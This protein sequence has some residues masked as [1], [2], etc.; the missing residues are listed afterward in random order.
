MFVHQHSLTYIHAVDVKEK[1]AKMDKG[2][3]IGSWGQLQ[4]RPSIW[5]LNRYSTD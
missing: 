1:K 3:H 4:G 2:I 5:L